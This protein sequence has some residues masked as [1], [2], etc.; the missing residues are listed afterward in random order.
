MNFEY[1]LY[2]VPGEEK[3]DV[4]LAKLKCDSDNIMVTPLNYKIKFVN[5]NSIEKR[6]SWLD[7]DRLPMI[8]NIETYWLYKDSA[9]ID[10]L[11]ELGVEF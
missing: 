3:S 10:K 8:V 4:V 6:E 11:E 2:A 9:C 1:V 5:P 7:L